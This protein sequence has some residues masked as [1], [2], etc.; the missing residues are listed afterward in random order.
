LK[1]APIPIR[2]TKLEPRYNI[3]PK[4]DLPIIRQGPKEPVRELSF[5]RWELIPSS[6]RDSYIAVKMINARSE[7][8]CTKPAF[9]DAL[10]SRSA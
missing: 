10:K 4:Q 9:G 6:A 1:S 7:T 5:V 2:R 3:A 8:A